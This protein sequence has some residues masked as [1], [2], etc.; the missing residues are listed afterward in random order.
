M[1][2]ALLLLEE[3]ENELDESFI[4][5]EIQRIGLGDEFI[6]YINAAFKFIKN[7]PEASE[8]KNKYIYRHVISKF[9]YWYII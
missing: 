7:H 1:E 3:A 2:Y 8:K 5:Y 6:N 4:W 9:P